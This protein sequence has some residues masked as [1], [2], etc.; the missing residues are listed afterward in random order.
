M[1]LKNPLKYSWQLY[2][3]SIYCPYIKPYLRA[4]VRKSELKRVY[5]EYSESLAL[6]ERLSQV[7]DLTQNSGE[8]HAPIFICATGWRTGS[9]LLQRLVMSSGEAL[10]WGEPYSDTMPSHALFSH[11]RAFKSDY[12]YDGCFQPISSDDVQALTTTWTACLFPPVQA[13]YDAHQ[14][15]FIKLLQDPALKQGFKH[16][17]MKEVRLNIDQALY[18]NWLFPN[19]K[20]IFLTRNPIDAYRSYKG[21]AWY[22]QWPN[23]RVDTATD[24]ATFWSYLA[25]GFATQVA[26]LKSLIVR[27]EDLIG[28]DG[29]ISKI[30]DFIELKVDRT[31]LGQRIEE[32]IRKYSSQLSRIEV[33]LI[34]KIAGETAGQLGYRL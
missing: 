16:W 22:I 3:R 26:G 30:E 29:E 34:K 27:Y 28:K 11:L 19:A 1:P 31:L 33:S 6:L 18:L 32:P 24:F 4:N 15:F 12:P 23:L 5:G 2:Y 14:S 8:S 17:G 13:L 9:T 20:F 7:Y 10:I 25:E 21:R